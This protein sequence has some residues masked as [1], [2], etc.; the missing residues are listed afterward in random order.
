MH[1][2]QDISIKA[3]RTTMRMGRS[4]IRDTNYSAILVVLPARAEMPH[5]DTASSSTELFAVNLWEAAKY[6]G[7]NGNACSLG[8]GT[9]RQR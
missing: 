3:I 1:R 9:T 5:L 4:R 8:L 2:G 6:G 7:K